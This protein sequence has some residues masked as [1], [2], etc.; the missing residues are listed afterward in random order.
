M[1]KTPLFVK[2]LKGKNIYDQFCSAYAKHGQIYSNQIL[3]HDY[4]PIEE[5]IS[6][7]AEHPKALTNAFGWTTAREYGIDWENV[8]KSWKNFLLKYK[9]P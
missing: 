6:M 7:Y 1:N 4:L 8:F 5:Y 9:T 2:F 3:S